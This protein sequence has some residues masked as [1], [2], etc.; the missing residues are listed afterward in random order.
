MRHNAER[1][2]GQHSG[3]ALFCEIIGNNATT[4]AHAGSDAR[5]SFLFCLT[6]H[7]AIQES[8]ELANEWPPWKSRHTPVSVL[9]T[10]TARETADDVKR[11]NMQSY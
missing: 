11:K 6:G 5:K 1:E 10:L 7:V 9:R 8:V 4:S 2:A 3:T